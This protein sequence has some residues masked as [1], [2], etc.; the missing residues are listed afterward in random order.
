MSAFLK[1]VGFVTKEATI[2]IEKSVK[3]VPP[4]KINWSY[5]DKIMEL[6]H[7]NQ[8]S[9]SYLKEL[10]KDATETHHTGAILDYLRDS[11]KTSNISSQQLASLK[12]LAE[13]KQGLIEGKNQFIQ[14][15]GE[16][17]PQATEFIEKLL[18]E[19]F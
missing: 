3:R 6:Q 13:A 18:K 2:A 4:P 9:P 14:F 5:K 19:L 17:K 11:F 8:L 15:V 7:D 16:A 10:V 12:K 1:I